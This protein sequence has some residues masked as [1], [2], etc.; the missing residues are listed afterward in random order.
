M[1]STQGRSHWPLQPTLQNVLDSGEILLMQT[2]S[3]ERDTL[4]GDSAPTA[5]P[6]LSFDKPATRGL[7]TF[8]PQLPV[9]TCIPYSCPHTRARFKTSTVTHC[10]ESSA[11]YHIPNS[12]ASPLKMYMNR[13]HKYN[14]ALTSNWR[15]NVDGDSTPKLAEWAPGK[16]QCLEFTCLANFLLLISINVVLSTFWVQIFLAFTSQYIYPIVLQK[17]KKIRSVYFRS[18]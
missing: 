2:R 18:R 6:A 1:G 16:E 11:L 10:W 9:R 4:Q 8:P 13:G 5:S 15:H 3:S 17:N 12:T 14:S 7:H